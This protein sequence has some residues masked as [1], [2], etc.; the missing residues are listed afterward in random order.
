MQLIFW[1]IETAEVASLNIVF[2]LGGVVFKWQPDVIIGRVF[3]DPLTRDLVKANIFEHADWLELDRGTL[4]EDEAI[5]RG[6][7]RT[8]LPSVDIERLFREVPGSL[9]PIPET[10]ELVHLLRQ[11]NNKLFVLS[12]MHHVSI[13][14]LEK[15]CELW[16]L[17]DGGVISCRVQKIKPEPAIYKL[18]LSEYALNVSQTVFIDDTSENLAAASALGIGAIK[19]LDADDC[20]RE[21]TRLECL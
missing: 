21:L 3:Q 10:I 5:R 6:A 17:F 12:N 19:F 8:G 4:A 9:V 1:W 15:T 18:L 7:A 13:T 20:K 14:H 2:D 16:H 11:S